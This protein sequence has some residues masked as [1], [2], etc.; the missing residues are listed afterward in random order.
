MLACFM[1]AFKKH[2][3]SNCHPKSFSPFFQPLFRSKFI[4]FVKKLRVSQEY[5][6]NNMWVLTVTAR[7]MTGMY[8]KP[9]GVLLNSDRSRWF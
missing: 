2:R 8:I 4:T 7:H 9:N 5:I 6:V 3:R 1:T